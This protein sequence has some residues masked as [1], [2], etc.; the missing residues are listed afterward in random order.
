MNPAIASPRGPAAP[1]SRN[2]TP[3]SAAMNLSRR[4]APRKSMRSNPCCPLPVMATHVK[5]HHAKYSVGG[6]RSARSTAGRIRR[7]DMNSHNFWPRTFTEFEF[8]D[9]PMA[10][11]RSAQSLPLINRRDAASSNYFG[12]RVPLAPPSRAV[13]TVVQRARRSTSL[14]PPELSPGTTALTESHGVQRSR[15][16][17]PARQLRFPDPGTRVRALVTNVSNPMFGSRR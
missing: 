10:S 8:A 3:F 6:R 14:P 12:T 7:G 4:A 11:R 17:G 15:Q 2:G 5:L 1:A 16:G 13:R 9:T